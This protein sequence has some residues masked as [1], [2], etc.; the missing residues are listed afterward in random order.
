[1]FNIVGVGWALIS[2]PLFLGFVGQIVGWSSGAEFDSADTAMSATG[3]ALFHT[4]FNLTN[5]VLLIWFVPQ[6]VRLAERTVASKG[7]SDE[8]FKLDFIGGPLGSTAELCILEAEKEVSKFGSVTARMNGFVKTV[9][10]SSS[11]KKK[12]KL[13][14]KLEKYE[15]ITDRVE[16]EIADY[17][18]KAARLEMSENASVKMRGMLSITNDLE[19]VGDI[20]YQISKTL[21]KKEQE[22]IY[23]TPEQRDGLNE[24]LDLVDKAF[25]VMNENIKEDRREVSME[26]AIEA[27]KE[28]NQFRNKLRKKHLKLIEKG[29][30][31][32]QGALMYSNIFS[33][34]EK[35][36]DHVINVSEAAAGEI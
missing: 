2:F 23:F 20:F 27:E 19:R 9:I 4:M 15:E 29:E 14:G 6:L 22:K 33:S 31:N 35:V 24:M 10:N 34:L 1:M 36:G 26:K 21:E 7:D 25:V 12:N 30:V 18:A 28:I 11:K 32:M 3:I 17:L 8:E 16:V 5:V 13:F